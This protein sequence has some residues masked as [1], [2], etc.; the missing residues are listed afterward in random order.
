MILKKKCLLFLSFFP[1]LC[2]GVEIF[3]NPYYSKQN[4]SVSTVIEGGLYGTKDY[5]LESTHCS[6]TFLSKNRHSFQLRITEKGILPG[7]FSENL[8]RTGVLLGISSGF[9]YTF[10]LFPPYGGISVFLESGYG[11]TGVYFSGGAGIGDRF[12][13]GV[14][15][16]IEY[17]HNGYLLSDINFYFQILK[18]FALQGN[19]SVYMELTQSSTSSAM[20]TPLV[21]KAGIF[22]GIHAGKFLRFNVG[23]GVSINDKFAFGFYTSLF[24]SS[25]IPF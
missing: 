24:F 13:N 11:T 25:R 20:E 5:F 1:S 17:L 4:F 14:F 22:P 18:Y 23:G 10:K 16:I 21:V 3:G 9:E 7:V 8:P 6:Y 2:F 12:S 19:L 15:L